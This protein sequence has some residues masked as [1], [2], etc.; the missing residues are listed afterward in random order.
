MS[1]KKAKP[2]RTPS[3]TREEWHEHIVEFL[4]SRHCS[5]FGRSMP[6]AMPDERV[7]TAAWYADLIMRAGVKDFS[8]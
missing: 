4:E 6:S 5:T 3:L 1:K 2:A 7:N 8:D